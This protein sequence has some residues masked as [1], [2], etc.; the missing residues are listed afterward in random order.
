MVASVG[1]GLQLTFANSTDTRGK[2]ALTKSASGRD[3]RC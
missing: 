1:N 2:F 3:E